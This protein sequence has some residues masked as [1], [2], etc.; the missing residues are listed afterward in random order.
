MSVQVMGFDA[1]MYGTKHR[2]IGRYVEELASY[3]AL[4]IPEKTTLVF[5]TSE[6]DLSGLPAGENIR[7]IFVD[8][9]VR[10]SWRDLA[11]FSKIIRQSGVN[12]MHFPHWNAPVLNDIPYLITL[13]DVILDSQRRFTHRATTRSWI[14]AEA[15]YFAY[16]HLVQSHVKKSRAIIAVSNSA[17][18]EI[19]RYYPKAAKKIHVVWNGVS[20]KFFQNSHDNFCCKRYNTSGSFLLSVG[21]AY[22][23]K[24]LEGFFKAF[25]AAHRERQIAW[26]IAGKRDFFMNRFEKMI[27]SSAFRD[28]VCFLGERTDEEILQDIAHAKALVFPSFDEGFGL[29]VLEAQA[30]SVPVL[31]SDIPVLREI[32]GGEAQ[33]FDPHRVD[34][35]TKKL[36]EFLQNSAWPQSLLLKAKNNTLGFRWNTCAEKTQ[37]IFLNITSHE[38][39]THLS[40]RDSNSS[41]EA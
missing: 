16:R 20:E 1:R 39:Q 34:D 22:P 10:Y 26:H 15:K 13:H 36:E 31:C 40:D 6:R 29:P 21:A 18:E 7:V 27:A 4:H 2:G 11:H 24:N 28:V 32:S 17:S 3:Y 19:S 8:R 9:P 25:A 23:H 37:K 30:L 14:H 5:F 33:F 41:A 35:M 12:A 38:S